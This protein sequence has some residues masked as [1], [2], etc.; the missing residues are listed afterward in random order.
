M[1][2][3]TTLYIITTLILFALNFIANIASLGLNDKRE[4][5]VSTII[6]TIIAMGFLVWGITLL[7]VN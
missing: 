2:L 5:P 1:G 3:A 4:F 6:A 7:V